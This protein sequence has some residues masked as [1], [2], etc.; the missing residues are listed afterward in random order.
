MSEIQR[1]IDWLLGRRVGESAP[2]RALSAREQLGYTKDECRDNPDARRAVRKLYYAQRERQEFEKSRDIGEIPEVQNPERRERCYTSLKLFIEE[3]FMDAE[4]FNLPWASFHLESIHKM[5][6][7]IINGGLFALALP[8]GS[9]KSSL[10]ERAIIWAILYGYR[11]YIVA[12]GDGR[13]AAQ[14]ILETVQ[15]EIESNEKLIA[16]FPE[17]CYPI[18]Q[19]QGIVQRATGQRY[20]GSAPDV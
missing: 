7:S 18:A 9:G 12:I 20:H 3:Y 4:K 17:V 16:D 8:R 10:S 2:Q 6:A 11:H 15:T 19:L 14:E 13:S 5:E 1:M